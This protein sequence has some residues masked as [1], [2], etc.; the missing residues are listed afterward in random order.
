METTTSMADFITTM[1]SFVTGLMTWMNS[2]LGFVTENPV[3][4]VFLLIALAG[5]VIGIVR[6]WL[7]GRG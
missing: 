6:R 7:P 4:M 1:S 5:T 2:F 3:L